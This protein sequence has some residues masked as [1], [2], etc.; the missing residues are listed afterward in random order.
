MERNQS[1]KM[2]P[3]AQMPDPIPMPPM[4]P[5]AVTQPKP[6]KAIGPK[7][8]TKKDNLQYDK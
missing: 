7:P 3:S 4:A 1:N 8:E 5:S 2:S 6:D